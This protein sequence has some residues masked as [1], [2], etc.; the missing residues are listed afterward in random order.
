MN[1]SFFQS[2]QIFRVSRAIL[3]AYISIR[4]GFRHGIIVF[5]MDRE[6]KNTGVIREDR[7][8]A[9]TVVHIR[10]HSHR[11]ADG[12]SGLEGPNRNGYVVEHAKPFAMPGIRMVETSGEVCGK[13]IL[14]STAPRQ[15]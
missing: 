10:V 9:I 3:K 11:R 14:K 4:R 12:P 1:Q 2:V 7:R 13:S 6:R 8:R 15:D 5:L